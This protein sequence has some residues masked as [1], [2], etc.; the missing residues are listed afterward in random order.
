MNTS[1]AYQASKNYSFIHDKIR[2]DLKDDIFDI[3]FLGLNSIFPSVE[4]NSIIFLM[5]YILDLDEKYYNELIHKIQKGGTNSSH[6]YWHN[7]TPLISNDVGNTQ[8]FEEI[9][10]TIIQRVE[11]QLSNR[12]LPAIRD[13]WIYLEALESKDD[14]TFEKLQLLLQFNEAFIREKVIYQFFK[15]PKILDVNC[16]HGLFND[17][18]PTVIFSAIR[19]SL[20]NWFSYSKEVK[21]TI[22][23]FISINLAPN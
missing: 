9:D 21:E 10:L 20:L 23:K 13:A 14:V 2:E 15:R 8:I 7:N 1:T 5:N 18:H 16:I 11:M 12:I 4:D 3:A 17:E 6:I 19:A 22:L